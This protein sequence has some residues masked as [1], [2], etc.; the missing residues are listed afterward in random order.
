MASR[1]FRRRSAA[2]AW[3]YAAVACGILRTIVAAR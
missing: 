2:A 3:I 1:V